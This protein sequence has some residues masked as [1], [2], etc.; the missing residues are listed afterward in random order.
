MSFRN[1]QWVKFDNEFAGAHKAADGKTVGLFVRGGVDGLGQSHVDRIMV[2]DDDGG[3]MLVVEKGQ[4]KSVEL[5]P[6]SAVGLCELDTVADIPAKRRETMHDGFMLK[7]DREAAKLA[8]AK[9][10]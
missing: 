4:V 7:A 10:A 9:P 1:G 6:A 8:A 3:N 5:S 2:V